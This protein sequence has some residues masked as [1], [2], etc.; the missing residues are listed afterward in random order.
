[1]NL[2]GKITLLFLAVN[3]VQVPPVQEVVKHLLLF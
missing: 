3:Q 1:M 2:R